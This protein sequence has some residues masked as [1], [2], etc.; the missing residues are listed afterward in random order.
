[1]KFDGACLRP[2]IPRN[3]IG[4]IHD[5]KSTSVKF[6]DDATVA[7]TV[8]LK[9]SL[10]PDPITRQ[11][12]LN[13]NEQN[14]LTLPDEQNLLSLYLLELIKFSKD[15]KMKINKEKT[16]I[17]TF[18]L[19]RNFNF[20]PEIGFPNNEH[21]EVVSKMRVLGVTLSDDLKWHDNTANM[22][23]KARQRL[24][25]IIRLKNLH[26]DNN[27]LIDIYNKEIRSIL[28]FACPV[29]NG[30]LSKEDSGKI[31]KIQKAFLRIIMQ[32]NLTDYKNTCNSLN[33][34]TLEERRLILCQK[35]INKEYKNNT[36]KFLNINRPSKVLRNP[37]VVK[38]PQCKTEHYFNSSLPYLTRMLNAMYS[39]K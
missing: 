34:Q 12:P 28:E 8:N 26:M 29:W 23:A 21:F 15:N 24:W 10:I 6:M 1:M 3:A 31:E 36:G 13:Y 39:K 18:N 32:K 22:C 9:T 27:T 30:A 7:V 16:K 17:M 14:S 5:S 35:F 33:M 38:E 19:S 4:P 2:K 20:P 37:K 25:I 11:K